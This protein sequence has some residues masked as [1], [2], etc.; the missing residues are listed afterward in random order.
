MKEIEWYCLEQLVEMIFIT[1][2]KCPFFGCNTCA[3]YYYTNESCHDKLGYLSPAIS[4]YDINRNKNILQQ[5]TQ[6]FTTILIK[7]FPYMK[8]QIEAYYFERLL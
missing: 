8:E 7:E 6:L 1:D 2:C 5:R 4:E 3:I